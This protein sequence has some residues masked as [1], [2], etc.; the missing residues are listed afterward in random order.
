[1]K[2]VPAWAALV[3][4]LFSVVSFSAP[5]LISPRLLKSRNSLWL[6]FLKSI[7]LRM[8]MS[9]EYSTLPR[10]LRGARAISVMVAFR[11]SS[12][13]TSPKALP[14]SFSYGPTRPSGPKTRPSK[15]GDSDSAGSITMRVMWASATETI[16][17]VPAARMNAVLSSL[18]RCAP[19]TLEPQT[20]KAR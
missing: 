4:L 14:R 3:G 5:T 16:A 8:K 18:M 1:M 20:T 13:S 11:G 7:G 10:V 9:I 12:G 2:P 6:P 19:D 15:A 17:A